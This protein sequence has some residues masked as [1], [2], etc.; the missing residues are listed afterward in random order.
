MSFDGLPSRLAFEVADSLAVEFVSRCGAVICRGK[1]VCTLPP[2][3]EWVWSGGKTAVVALGES[4]P[5]EGAK[6]AF[7]RTVSIE[8]GILNPCFRRFTSLISSTLTL[9]QADWH[10]NQA[11]DLGNLGGFRSTPTLP[12]A[13]LVVKGGRGS[14]GRAGR[15]LIMHFGGGKLFTLPSGGLNPALLPISRPKKRRGRGC[16]WVAPGEKKEGRG[17]ARKL[18]A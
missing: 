14:G 15:A 10:T 18:S 16:P 11:R 7:N 8:Q 2:A 12:R 17:A 4:R 6:M 1:T 3:L 5:Q 9:R 13:W